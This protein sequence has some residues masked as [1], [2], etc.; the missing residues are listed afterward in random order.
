MFKATMC[1]CGGEEENREKRVT[2]RV[3][4]PFFVGASAGQAPNDH[5]LSSCLFNY[6]PR[7]D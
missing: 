6:P 7:P 4:G 2:L 1:V 3:R 5:N